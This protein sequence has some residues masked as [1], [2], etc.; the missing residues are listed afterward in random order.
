[1]SVPTGFREAIGSG[2]LLP[3]ALSREREV[4]THDEWRLLNRTSKLLRAR[5]I[6]MLLSCDHDQC[7]TIG[8]IARVP[9]PGG[10]VSLQC[11]HKSREFQRAF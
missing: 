6:T 4:W 11:A 1:M 9:L 5:G 3:T 2:L 8:P 7:R 10:G